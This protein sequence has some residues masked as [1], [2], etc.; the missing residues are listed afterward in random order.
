MSWSS[1]SVAIRS[2]QACWLQ[3]PQI[4]SPFPQVQFLMNRLSALA[5]AV[6]GIH[7]VTL[8]LF[9]NQSFLVLVHACIALHHLRR[10]SSLSHQEN[11]ICVS[12]SVVLCTG[13]PACL[14]TVFFPYTTEKCWATLTRT[15]IVYEFL[16]PLQNAV[17][18]LWTCLYR[19]ESDSLSLSQSSPYFLVAVLCIQNLCLEL[20]VFTP[21]T[22][23][24]L[25]PKG[26][27]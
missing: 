17:L 18:L 4:L 22:P 26:V 27:V 14:F 21:Q 10:D 13:C 16:H 8:W 12:M 20:L 11:W 24:V 23:T 6:A 15:A 19:W 2:L 7:P 5:G 3:A 1:S 9:K 25:L